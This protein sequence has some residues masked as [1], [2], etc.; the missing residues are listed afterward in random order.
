MIDISSRPH[1]SEP[2][3]RIGCIC[4]SNILNRTVNYILF[5][6]LDNLVIRQKADF[7]FEDTCFNITFVF[8]LVENKKHR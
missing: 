5:K 3:N 7:A 2:D 1:S 8:N 6:L 4:A